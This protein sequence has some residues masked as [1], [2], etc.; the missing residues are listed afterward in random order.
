[1][2]REQALDKVKKLLALADRAGTQGEAQ[3]ALAQAMALAT[4]H[5]ITEQEARA[6]ENT[7]EQW[8]LVYRA[9]RTPYHI[10][11]LIDGVAKM[12]GCMMFLGDD[13]IYV[14]GRAS[15]RM[16]AKTIALAT[17]D[18]MHAWHDRT[19]RKRGKSVDKP[20][21]CLAFVD[22]LLERLQEA[23]NEVLDS[24]RTKALAV[25]TPEDRMLNAKREMDATGAF[26]P[27]P[28]AIPPKHGASA[29]LGADAASKTRLPGEHIALE[30]DE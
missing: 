1:M 23:Q 29:A 17:I 5:G 3:A 9:K 10:K 7:K 16:V 28:Q 30:G 18:T 25:I 14:W 13:G 15:D 26:K 6:E 19:E 2:T 11:N 22:Q 20:S 24:V 21:F 8:T 4:K 27:A 12:C